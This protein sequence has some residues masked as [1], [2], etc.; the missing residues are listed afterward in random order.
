[1]K[2]RLLS[3]FYACV[4]VF[5]FAACRSLPEPAGYKVREIIRTDTVMTSDSVL[6]DRWHFV[7]EQGDTVFVHDSV[8]IDR[9]KYRDKIIVDLRVDSVPYPVEV[10]REVPVRLNTWQRFILGSGYALWGILILA[11][12]SFILGIVLSRKL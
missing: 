9:L 12:V 3:Y 1:M 2:G 10:V 5:L 7:K 4:L 11:I 8:Y 6:V